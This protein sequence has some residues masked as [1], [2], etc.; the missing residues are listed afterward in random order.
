MPPMLALSEAPLQQVEV[1]NIESHDMSLSDIRIRTGESQ[2]ISRIDSGGAPR[3]QHGET[4]RP[5]Q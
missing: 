3:E 1:G 5:R 4:S 2:V